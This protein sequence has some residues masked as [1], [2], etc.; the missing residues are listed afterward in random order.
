[1]FRELFI[2]LSTNKISEKVLLALPFGMR[3]AKRFVA[4]YLVDELMDVGLDLQQR[5]YKVT[6]DHLGEEVSSRKLIKKAIKDYHE[7]L[8]EISMS[9]IKKPSISVKLSQI[10]LKVGESF[11][12]KNLKEILTVAKVRGVRV[13]IDM[14][15]SEYKDATV[16]MYKKVLK[17]FPGTGMAIQAYL[18]DTPND[19]RSIIKLKGAS[20][21]LVKGAYMESEEIA[22]Q[23]KKE[24][25]LNFELCLNMMFSP[26]AKKN[27]FRPLV[28]THDEKLLRTALREAKRNK[29]KYTDFEFEMLYGI[30][31]D[32][33]RWLLGKGYCVRLYVPYG[34]AWYPYFMRRLAERPANTWFVLKNLFK[35]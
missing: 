26:E 6:A 13:E 14:E 7:L 8:E 23:D 33:Q 22:F 9:K 25:D 35:G 3:S 30:R 21:R 18:F 10:G 29:W 19:L 12:L 1:M 24:V 5:G 27:K 17:K 28:G 4:G 16:K 31:R 34:D 20:I 32:L 11:A 15:S 2:K